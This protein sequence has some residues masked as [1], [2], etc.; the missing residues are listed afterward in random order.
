M[1]AFETLQ[2]Q[3]ANDLTATKIES[4]KPVHAYSGNIRTDIPATAG[5]R[6]HLVEELLP[7][8][9]WGSVSAFT[10]CIINIPESV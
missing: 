5:S 10:P 3:S 4:D 6:D 2:I 1:Q 8:T 9:Q 7:T